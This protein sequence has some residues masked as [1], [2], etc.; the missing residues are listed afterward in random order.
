MYKNK[1]D[2]IDKNDTLIFITIFNFYILSIVFIPL[3]TLIFSRVTKL[4]DFLARLSLFVQ[5]KKNIGGNN[6]RK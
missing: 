4:N 5:N 1:G 6:G 2:K 3:I